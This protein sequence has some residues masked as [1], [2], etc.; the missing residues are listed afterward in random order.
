[1]QCEKLVKMNSTAKRVKY[2]EAVPKK[3]LSDFL[4]QFEKE[5]TSNKSEIGEEPT[6][7]DKDISQTLHHLEEGIT[8]IRYCL[9]KP[10]SKR[11]TLNEVNRKVD[12]I[13]EILNS[14]N[15]N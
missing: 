8:S 13:L 1:M 10:K 5:A 4:A 3:D 6:T 12:L 15:T 14:W 7:I 11:I 2:D 9:E